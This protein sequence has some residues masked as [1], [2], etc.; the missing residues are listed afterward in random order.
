MSESRANSTH[1]LR[2]L[3]SVVAA[4]ALTL[5]VTQFVEA[6]AGT[7][8]S[9]NWRVVPAL[10]AFLVTLVPFYHG[11][12][13]YLDTTYE[14]GG[15][16]GK[17]PG[18]VLWDFGMLFLEACILLAAASLVGDPMSFVLAVAALWAVDIVWVAVGRALLH[19][20]NP[21][22]WARINGLAVVL[23]TAVY[24]LA[25]AMPPKPLLTGIFIF[26]IS[27][28]RTVA[29]YSAAWHLYFPAA[30]DRRGS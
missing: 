19:L 30:E 27:A 1:S 3:Y 28:A 25:R 11:A 6:T 17:H 2:D 26:V 13:Q 23:L 24:L 20:R 14:R 9:F 22:E 21:V 18:L 8:P 4:L 7:K 12:V 5:A 29:D 16:G 15:P 10:L